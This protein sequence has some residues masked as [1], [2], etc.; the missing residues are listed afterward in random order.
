MPVI[1]LI[2]A[3]NSDALSNVKFADIG[4]R[5]AIL[6][7]WAAGDDAGD[8]IGLSVG[9]RDIIVPSEVNIEVTADVIDV[10]RDQLLFDE[11]VPPGHIFLPI[12]AT[13]EVQFLLT[14]R[15]L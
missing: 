14:I 2:S 4:G 8:T 9:D 15:Y 7:L 1:K 13:A 5:G 3:S 10:Q 11:V 6:N 12:V